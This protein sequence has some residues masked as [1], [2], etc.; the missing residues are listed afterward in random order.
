MN[1]RDRKVE[2]VVRLGLPDAASVLADERVE[3]HPSISERCRSHCE[4]SLRK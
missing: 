4:S 1:K 3:W 2:R